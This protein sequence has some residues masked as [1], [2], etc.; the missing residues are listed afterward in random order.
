MK[1]KMRK[2]AYAVGNVILAMTSMV[3]ATLIG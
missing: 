3:L 1:K 2:T